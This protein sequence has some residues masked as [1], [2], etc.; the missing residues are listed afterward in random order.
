MKIPGIPNAP[1]TIEFD[2]KECALF[3]E[4]INDSLDLIQAKMFSFV[5]DEE[6]L[7]FFRVFEG[8][9]HLVFTPSSTHKK[10]FSLLISHELDKTDPARKEKVALL[11]GILNKLNYEHRAN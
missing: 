2:E 4:A 9:S 7:K 11:K 8:T 5:S 3:M 10:V 1:G 6:L